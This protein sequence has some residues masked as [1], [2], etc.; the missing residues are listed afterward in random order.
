M[1]GIVLYISRCGSTRQYAEWIG[2]ETGFPII[3]LKKDKEPD[4]CGYDIIV[5]GSWILAGKM[6]AHSW[7]KKNWHRIENKNV[8]VFSVSGDVPDEEIRKKYLDASFPNG[9]GSRISFYSFHGRFRKEDQNILLRGMLNFAA[10]FEKEGNLANNLVLG[11][12]GV[13]KENIKGI[14]DQIKRLQ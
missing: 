10:K 8:F 1:K 5:I 12:D 9:I 4:L 2:E 3:D 13:K 6:V 7:I 14:I 11:V